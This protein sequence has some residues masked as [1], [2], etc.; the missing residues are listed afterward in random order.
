MRILIRDQESLLPWIGD[1]K[2]RIRDK[3]PGSA[4]LQTGNRPG[5]KSRLRPDLDR[6]ISSLNCGK[7]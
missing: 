5:Q 1:L 7:M 6:T 3:P 4:T 2:I